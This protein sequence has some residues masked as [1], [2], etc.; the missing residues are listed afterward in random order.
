MNRYDDYFIEL[1]ETQLKSMPLACPRCG[2][3]KMQIDKPTHNALSRHYDVHI[4]A[5]CGTYEALR[6]HEEKRSLPPYKW[7]F[8]R[9]ARSGQTFLDLLRSGK[10]LDC[11]LII[12]GAEMPADLVWSSESRMTLHGNLI[13]LQLLGAPYELLPNGNYVIHCDNEEMGIDF[14]QS[15][16]G[17]TGNM[18]YQS[19]FCDNEL[20]ADYVAV[21]NVT[22]VPETDSVQADFFL[23]M[24]A[25]DRTGWHSI[26]SGDH[27][28]ISIS[29]KPNQYTLR[30]MFH[31]KSVIHANKKLEIPF[32]PTEAEHHMLLSVLDAHCL[33]VYCV[34]LEQFHHNKWSTHSANANTGEEIKLPNGSII[35]CEKN[36]DTTWESFDIAIHHSDGKT[37]M[38]CAV[39]Y[40]KPL[41]RVRTLLFEQDKE[42]YTR[43]HIYMEVECVDT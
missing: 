31:Y 40:D 39:D 43:E 14:C 24:I 34:S 13:Y 20:N 11:S 7:H 1:R 23:H 26:A 38:I 27:M 29:L 33:K 22:Y 10:E 35:K 25:S 8:I 12:G 2:L 16:A 6:V 17:Y 9:T 18:R 19:L 36:C 30:G 15:A 42:D 3:D 28:S 21:K 32:Y 5:D 4:C 41:G 37:D